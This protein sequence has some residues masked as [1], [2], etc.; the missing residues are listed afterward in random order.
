[1][2]YRDNGYRFKRYGL[3]ESKKQDPYD[4]ENNGLLQYILSNRIINSEN[5]ILQKVLKYYE[6]NIIF[7]LKYID[8]LKHFKNYHWKNR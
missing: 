3:W 7:V 2:E 5:E 4:Y 8:R 1:M 6:Y